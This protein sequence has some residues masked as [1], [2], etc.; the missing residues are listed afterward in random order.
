MSSMRVF[1]VKRAALSCVLGFL[2]PFGYTVL[3]AG[4][5]Y[6]GRRATPQFLVWPVGWPRPLL[7]L[8]FGHPPRPEEFV[9]A[10]TLL[11][12]CNTLLYGALAYVGLT[13]LSTVGRKPAG[14]EPPPP[15][16]R[17]DSE[18]E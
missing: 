12:V 11:A 3:L 10:V 4:T 15:P 8:L 16:G 18:A 2:I 5:F 7:L 9:A 14:Y 17:L 6:Y 13:L 1:S